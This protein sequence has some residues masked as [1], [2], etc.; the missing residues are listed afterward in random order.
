[1]SFCARASIPPPLPQPDVGAGAQLPQAGLA[2]LLFMSPSS[3]GSS[4]L[5]HSRI[6]RP[7]CSSQEYAMEATR[8]SSPPATIS[9][10]IRLVPAIFVDH[11]PS[12]PALRIA[13]VAFVPQP[14][15][16]SAPRC[17]LLSGADRGSCPCPL[18][19]HAGMCARAARLGAPS[20]FRS[21]SQPRASIAMAAGLCFPALRFRSG[22]VRIRLIPSVCLLHG[23]V[24]LPCG[25]S[26]SRVIFIL[27]PWASAPLSVG[28]TR[29]SLVATRGNSGLAYRK[30]GQSGV[31]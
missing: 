28:P 20:S 2:S 15:R 13:V 22:V 3:L 30:L 12:L 17:L 18:T 27:N 4:S 16:C 25:I 7:L 8:S 11:R 21:P 10:Q 14:K 5:S 1:M 31:P 23:L 6:S 24:L 26:D 29:Q 9:S 19:S